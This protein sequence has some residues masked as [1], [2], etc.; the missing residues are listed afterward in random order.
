[1][2]RNGYLGNRIE[3]GKIKRIPVKEAAKM[4]DGQN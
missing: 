1:M 3:D 4:G 2:V